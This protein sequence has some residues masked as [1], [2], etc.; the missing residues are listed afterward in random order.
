[1]LAQPQCKYNLRYSKK[2]SRELEQQEET[3]PQVNPLV[4]YKGKGKLNPNPVMIKFPLYKE[5]NRS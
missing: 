4:L 3:T 2:R 5:I 1:M